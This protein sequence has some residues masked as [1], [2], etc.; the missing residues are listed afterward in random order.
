MN[1]RQIHD[2]TCDRLATQLVT[3]KAVTK[4]RYTHIDSLKKSNIQ[5]A[6]S[7]EKRRG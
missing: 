6:E 7:A 3:G 1:L 4:K 5:T 2:I